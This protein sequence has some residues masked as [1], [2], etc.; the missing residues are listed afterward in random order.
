MLYI[1][2]DSLTKGYGLFPLSVAL[3]YRSCFIPETT[4][5][6]DI[7]AKQHY[8]NVIILPSVTS[9]YRP[10]MIWNVVKGT[11]NSIQNISLFQCRSVQ[12]AMSYCGRIGRKTTKF[13]ELNIIHRRKYSMTTSIPLCHHLC[14]RR[15]SWNTST[16]VTLAILPRNGDMER[17][18]PLGRARTGSRKIL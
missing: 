3:G 11:F 9:R 1:D 6:C 5:S 7:S 2:S 12:S 4:F 16:M 15:S 18:C 17:P 10:D 14:P 13:W 8:K